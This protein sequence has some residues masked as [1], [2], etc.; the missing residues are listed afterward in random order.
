MTLR[1]P[2]GT[3]ATPLKKSKRSFVKKTHPGFE[4]N[5]LDEPMLLFAQNAPDTTPKRGLSTA[6]PAGFGSALHPS[7]ILVGIVGTGQ[8]HEKAKDFLAE[9]T[10]KIPGSQSSPRQVPSFP[11]MN[12]DSPFKTDLQPLDSHLGLITTTDLQN[13]VGNQDHAAGFKDAVEMLT[14]KVQLLCESDSP[15]NVV[16]CALPNELVEYCLQAGNALA[17][18]TPKDKLFSKLLKI[19]AARGQGHMLGD[20]FGSAPKSDFVGRN[21]RRALKA[22]TMKWHRPIQIGLESGLF[23]EK[24][25]PP[26]T[27]AWNFCV[28]LYYKAGGALPWKVE[29]LN[30]ETCFIGISFYRHMLEESFEMHT[31]LAQV[32]TGEGEA[33][34]L[35][36]HKSHWDNQKGKSPH[37]DESASEGLMELVL[38]KYSELKGG[39]PRR[40][41]VHKTSRF[42]ENELA[43]FRKGLHPVKEFDLLSIQQTGVRF[44]RAGAYPPLRGTLCSVNERT[45]SYTRW[46]ICPSLARILEAMFPNLG[47]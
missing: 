43:G 6:G 22:R 44:F 29:G 4:F 18:A 14:G 3:K 37:L 20:L 42:F 1:K 19:E 33:F 17:S 13:V 34:V 38:K 36:G 47:S 23:S 45:I 24:A 8:T 40:I 46:D 16:I 7:H 32:F 35:R 39:V 28:A 30:P 31:S 41:V 15:P 2:H 12:Q 27:K 9:C 11:G 21:L 25:Q 10:K 5:L 26:A